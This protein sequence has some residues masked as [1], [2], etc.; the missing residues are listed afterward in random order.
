MRTLE[1]LK[2]H[3]EKYKDAIIMVGPEITN[4]K[5][6]KEKFEK[7]LNKKMLI[8]KPKEFYKNFQIELEKSQSDKITESQKMILKLNE[9]ELTKGIINLNVDEKLVSP[10]TINLHGIISTFLCNKCNIIYPHQSINFDDISCEVC[11]KNIRPQM[12]LLG[13][14]YKD[15]EYQKTI[16]LL[17]KTHT[18]ITVGLDYKEEAIVDL[19]SGYCNIKSTSPEE[20]ILIGINKKDNEIN[21]IKINDEIGFHDFYVTDEECQLSLDRLMKGIGVL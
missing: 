11:G 2:A 7:Y 12:L 17:N 5:I 18:L 15:K 14:T 6:E 9:S 1:E 4:T 21:N 10:T 19:I 16:E 20:K 8:R 13:E 3:M